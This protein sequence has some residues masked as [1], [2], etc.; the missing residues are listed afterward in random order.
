MNRKNIERNKEMRIEKEE[1]T[2]VRRR[3]NNDKKE[4]KKESVREM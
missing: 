3:R 4:R 1:R 2:M